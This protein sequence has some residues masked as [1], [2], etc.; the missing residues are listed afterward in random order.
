[1]SASRSASV[2]ASIL[3]RL[4]STITGAR[5]AAVD[6]R[7]IALDAAHVEVAVETHH[8]EHGIDV[9]GDDLADMPLARRGARQ[10]GT[11][12]QH[13]FDHRRFGYRQ[14][15][16]IADRR[17]VSR[18]NR[19]LEKF[20]RGL[21]AEFLDAIVHDVAVAVLR[22]DAAD[23]RFGGQRVAAPADAAQAFQG[24]G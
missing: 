2:S 9:G 8:D 19:A 5:A 13:G 23:A 11:S 21:R 17:T 20:R 4:V 16:E 22:D 14:F 10:R 1:M 12:R 18:R 3:S 15:D 6:Q 7:E 24:I